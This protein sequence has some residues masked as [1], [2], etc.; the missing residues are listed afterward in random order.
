MPSPKL[1]GLLNTRHA[2]G[3]DVGRY[4]CSMTSNGIGR[5]VVAIGS[6]MFLVFLLLGITPGEPNTSWLPFM[7]SIF[8]V[9]VVL[10]G[11]LTSKRGK[12]P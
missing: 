12:H 2:S 5:F 3:L 10:V 6:L 7:G 1:V 8:A 9:V 11:Y 4:G